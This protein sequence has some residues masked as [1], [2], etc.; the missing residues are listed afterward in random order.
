MDQQI[1]I[2]KIEHTPA[3]K[4]PYCN[5]T[6]T[7]Q[8][9]LIQHVRTLHQLFIYTVKSEDGIPIQTNA[10]SSESQVQRTNEEPSIEQRYQQS[11][12]MEFEHS[13]FVAMPATQNILIRNAPT[14]TDGRLFHCDMCVKSFNS[15][16]E[17]NR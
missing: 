12:R 4:C 17:M 7:H 3:V 5:E 9:Q 16:E 14:Q 10:F 15:Q 11:D 1:K 2:E 8:D 13:A 6:F